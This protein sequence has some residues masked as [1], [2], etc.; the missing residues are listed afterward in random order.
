MTDGAQEWRVADYLIERIHQ[1]GV[2]TV[3]GVTGGGMM[4]LID[5]VAV[6]ADVSLVSTHHE[7]FAGVAADGYARSGRRYGVAF[8]TTGPGAAHLFTAVAAAYQ[9]SSPVVFVAG[10]VKSSDSSTIN[11]IAIRQNGTF[12]FDTTRAFAPISKHVAL[13]TS[14][15]AAPRMIDEA[16][17][18][19]ISGRPGPVVLEVPL[20]VQGTLIPRTLPAPTSPI[21]FP[22]GAAQEAKDL[23]TAALERSTK[24]LVLLGIGAVRSGAFEPLRAVLAE[25]GIPYVSTQFAREIGRREDPLY[26][27]SPGIKSNRSA[28]LAVTEC[29]L[30]IAI[31]TSLHQQVTG[32]EAEKFIETPSFKIW[33]EVDPNVLAARRH[34]VDEAVHLDS[35]QAA[36]T[37][38]LALDDAELPDID[39][40]RDT[41]AGW[42]E[43]HL[44]HYPPHVEV[45]G[46]DCLYRG[47]SALD[48]FSNRFQVAA[49]DAGLIWYAL[50]QHFMVRDG[51]HYVSSGSF[52]AMGMALP[53]A[54]GAA[55]ATDEPVLCV[56][57]DG[58]IM[59]CLAE[60]A[61][62]RTL[63]KRVVVVII[64]NDGY[65]SIRTTHDRYFEG[66]SIGT[67]ATN[68]VFIPSFRKVADTFDLA[69]Q[70]A[71]DASRLRAVIADYFAREATG[72]LVVEYYSYADQAVEPIVASFQDAEGRFHS[73]SL[74][75]MSPPIA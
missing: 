70:E 6:H 68:G 1:D 63:G 22:P 58:S 64:N 32:W 15:E 30:L 34:L 7:E 67:D 8:G 17:R 75:D 11:G 19:A 59:M 26:L 9:D 13:I 31:G 16:I 47:V 62:L 65:V 3:F 52:G 51:G 50:A 72:P 21:A 39:A 53:F 20:D 27:G 43:R 18:I 66:R 42:R 33:L 23:L 25:R 48:E 41:A 45:D 46:R 35:A 73:P 74:A 37:L 54:I 24:P 14:A 40:W 61:T 10:Q 38:M 69:Y 12:E 49:T 29:D 56:T 71:H 36:E 55:S 60:L 57:G 44:L 2:D 28:N 5:A 4:Y